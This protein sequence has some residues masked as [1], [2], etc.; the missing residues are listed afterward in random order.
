[1]EIHTLV[2]GDTLKLKGME[3]TLGKMET[4]MKVS[5]SSA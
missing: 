4:D 1:M 2:N 5:G 3:C